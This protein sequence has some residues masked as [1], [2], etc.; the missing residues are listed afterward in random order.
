[1]F[2]YAFDLVLLNGRDLR[3]EPVEVRKAVL[4]KLLRLRGHRVEAF[5]L[6]LRFRSVAGLDQDQE[7]KRASG[8]Q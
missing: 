2:L 8:A 3:R 7:S 4:E 5:G 1:M 6:A